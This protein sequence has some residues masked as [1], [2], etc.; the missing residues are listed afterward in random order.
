VRG[1]F[2]QTVNREIFATLSKSFHSVTLQI[3]FFARLSR[4][5]NESGA[6]HD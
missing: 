3:G 2:C 6:G 5:Y 4:A 1:R